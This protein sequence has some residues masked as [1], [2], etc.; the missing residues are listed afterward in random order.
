MLVRP[1]TSFLSTLPELPGGIVLGP[2]DILQDTNPHV[3]AR[4]E[5]FEEVRTTI[6][7]PADTEVATARPGEKRSTRAPRQ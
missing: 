1:T 5:M 7:D 4:P 2:L 6:D 3:R